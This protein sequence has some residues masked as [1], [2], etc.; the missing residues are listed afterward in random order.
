M[1]DCSSASTICIGKKPTL[2][3]RNL[4][5]DDTPAG[6]L[7]FNNFAI[8]PVTTTAD[9]S[10]GGEYPRLYAIVP[11]G[12]RDFGFEFQYRFGR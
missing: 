7:G 4:L 3:V 11:Q 1:P 9:A 12:G 10:N 2:Y 5:D 6:A 8:N